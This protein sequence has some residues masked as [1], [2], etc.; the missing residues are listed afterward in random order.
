MTVRS[1]KGH[2][3]PHSA[4]S[5]RPEVLPRRRSGRLVVARHR[6]PRGRSAHHNPVPVAPGRRYEGDGAHRSVETPLRRG[7]AV[8]ALTG[9]AVSLVG[10]ASPA[11]SAPVEAPVV[12]VVQAETVAADTL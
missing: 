7:A 3:A 9:G 4:G 11:A 8:V 1:R 5:P 10:A 6:S 12:P 2:G